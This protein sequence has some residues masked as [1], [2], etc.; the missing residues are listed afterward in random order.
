MEIQTILNFYSKKVVAFKKK[1][2]F[3]RESCDFR[4]CLQLW[5]KVFNH[6]CMN[7]GEKDLFSESP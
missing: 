5:D 4:N 1:S 2:L 3:V 7:V 6:N